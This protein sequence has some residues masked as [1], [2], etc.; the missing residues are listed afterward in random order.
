MRQ[1][2][3]ENLFFSKH[4]LRRIIVDTVLIAVV[5][6]LVFE[7]LPRS[8]TFFSLASVHTTTIQKTLHSIVAFVCVMLFRTL[9]VVYKTSWIS[10]KIQNYLNV[11]VADAVAGIVYY[12][13]TEYGLGSVYPF[14]LTLSM[15]T[16]IDILTLFIRL[17]YQGNMEDIEHETKQCLS[18]PDD[19]SEPKQ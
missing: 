10:A 2:N 18:K 7:I 19:R 9:L 11:I 3:R 1:I 8:A 13:I 17:F 14:L 4:S 15:F 16:M 5:A 12:F 6:L